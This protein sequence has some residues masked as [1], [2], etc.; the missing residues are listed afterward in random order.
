MADEVVPADLTKQLSDTCQ[1]ISRVLYLK[2]N[3]KGVVRF[4]YILNGN[5]FYFLEVNTVPGM[6]AAS[7]V[8]KMARAHG[9]SF[10]ELITR[11]LTDIIP[12]N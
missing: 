7:I 5:D 3:C 4:D 12:I 8:P 6:S 11:L 9:W 1:E 2:L 10:T